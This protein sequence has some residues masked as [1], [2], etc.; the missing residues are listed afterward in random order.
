MDA[1]AHLQQPVRKPS[2][3]NSEMVGAIRKTASWKCTKPVGV[4][5]ELFK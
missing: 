5:D 4:P 1:D 2:P 3:L